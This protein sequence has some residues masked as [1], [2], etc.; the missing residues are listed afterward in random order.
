MIVHYYE[1]NLLI[2]DL[3]MHSSKLKISI[4][5]KWSDK[6]FSFIYERLWSHLNDS[7]ECGQ[8]TVL[9]VTCWLDSKTPVFSIYDLYLMDQWGSE[10]LRE[11]LAVC[12]WAE[13]L[14]SS[15]QTSACS[16]CLHRKSCCVSRLLSS[17]CQTVLF[18][19]LLLSPSVSLWSL[20]TEV[21][22][23]II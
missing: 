6:T 4:I 19:L 16:L 7:D 22:L 21:C 1:C 9:Q 3:V 11:P 23:Y 15:V 20:T 12:V 18:Q 17:R 5:M 8:K 14:W 13:F 10:L 2:G